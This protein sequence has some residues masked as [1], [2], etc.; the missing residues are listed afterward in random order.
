[1]FTTYKK[2]VADIN[3]NIPVSGKGNNKQKSVKT[4]PRGRHKRET[5]LEEEKYINC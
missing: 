5:M 2:H 3:K 4:K 1:M